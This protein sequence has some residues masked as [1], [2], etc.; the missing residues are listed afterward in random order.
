MPSIANI[1]KRH[2]YNKNAHTYYPVLIVGA[3]ESGVAMGCRLKDVL[4]TDQFRIFERQSGIGGTWWINRYPG[5]ACDMSVLPDWTTLHPSGPE[6]A[7]YLADVC[8]KYQIVD[9]IQLHTDVE[10]VRWV[11]D[12]DEWEVTLSHLVPGTGD[13]SQRD[14]DELVAREGR[15]RVYI[16]TEVVRAKIVVSGVGGLVEPNTYPKDIPGFED[17]QGEI[18]HTARWNNDFDLQGK[19]VVVLGSGCSAA[20]VVPELVKPESNVHSVTQLMRTPPWVQPDI[21]SP[22]ILAWWETWMP[23]LMTHVPGL[24]R[25]LRNALFFMLERNFFAIFTDTRY[26]RRMRH[27]KEKAFLKNMRKFAPEKYHEILTPNYSLGCKRR[28]IDS[29]WYRSLNAPHVE[30]TTQPLTRVHAKSVTIGPGYHYPPNQKDPGEL[31]EIPADVII[32]GNGFETNQWLHPLRV[33]GKDNK[34]MEDVW[35]ERGGAQA[36]LGL[37]M[38]HFPNFFM[39][40]GPNT[41]TGHT[42]VIF[43]TENAVKYSLNF[44]KPI[45]DGQMASESPRLE[46]TPPQTGPGDQAA[47]PAPDS[48]KRKAEQTNG[49]H[50]RTKRNR[51]ISIAWYDIA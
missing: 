4:G 11:P 39:I 30:L 38:D 25:S 10:E 5:A 23:H 13:L 16:K 41:A 32:L 33:I 14:R 45:L 43:A 2:V 31:R 6:L 27:K 17:F 9:K 18:M 22:E 12:D 35:A 26:G 36:Y 49:T 19:D 48:A 37:A 24:A 42:S 20:Q 34:S 51:Y 21:L 46:H 50:T 29:T 44:I 28:I 1:H 3:G 7:Q 40:F 15:H 8:E 47:T